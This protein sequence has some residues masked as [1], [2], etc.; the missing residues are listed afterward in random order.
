MVAA[1]GPAVALGSV[2]LAEE[3]LAV[4]EPAVAGKNE[5]DLN[6]R[7]KFWKRSLKPRHIFTKEQL[8]SI[9]EMV[10]KTES[11]TTGEIRV[12]IRSVCKRGLS[13]K[14]QALADFEKHGLAQTHDKT[15]V[16]ILIVL[17]DRQVEIIADEGINGVVSEDYWNSVILSMTSSFKN[18]E[19]YKGICTAVEMVGETL[20]RNFPGKPD[21]INELPDAPV[22][23]S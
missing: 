18:R 4:A 3:A 7:L 6:M 11:L 19:F 15:G 8:N 5:R 17:Q 1:I 21:D 14:Q 22:V 9:T 12:V 13:T 2:D 23:T 20:A 16:L 10:K